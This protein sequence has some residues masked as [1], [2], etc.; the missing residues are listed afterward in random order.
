M[1]NLLVVWQGNSI[2][3]VSGLSHLSALLSL[4][5]SRN[6]LCKLTDLH[7][8]TTLRHLTLHANQLTSLSGVLLP[9]Y[10]QKL[11]WAVSQYM[12][13]FASINLSLVAGATR[14]ATIQ[15]V[16]VSWKVQHIVRCCSSRLCLANM[17]CKTVILVSLMQLH[18]G[19]VQA[20]LAWFL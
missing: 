2:T 20:C 1:T 3:Q 8:L 18:C 12:C 5:L 19:G 16:Q 9:P 15:C 10:W 17:I 6:R 13:N 7:N 14:K 11:L 4:N